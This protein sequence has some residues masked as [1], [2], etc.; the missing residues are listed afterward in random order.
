M[1]KYVAE[2]EVSIA[3]VPTEF[4]E[5]CCAIRFF[6]CCRRRDFRELGIGKHAWNYECYTVKTTIQWFYIGKNW[7]DP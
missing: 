5:P 4:L 6:R 7:T 2:G 3:H 1:T